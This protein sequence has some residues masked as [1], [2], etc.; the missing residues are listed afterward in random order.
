MHSWDT[1][2]LDSKN[3]KGWQRKVTSRPAGGNVNGDRF[4]VKLLVNIYQNEL[5]RHP[6][7]IV[8]LLESTHQK[9]EPQCRGSGAVFDAYTIVLLLISRCCCSWN[10]KSDKNKVSQGRSG[11]QTG[12]QEGQEVCPEGT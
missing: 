2:E 3:A 11:F 8:L 1:G 10:G 12:I 4:F 6:Q 7:P 5:H 9:Q